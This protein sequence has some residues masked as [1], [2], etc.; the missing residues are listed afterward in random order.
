[1]KLVI[2]MRDL[3]FRN[4]TSQEK[5][6]RRL[7]LSESVNQDGMS[8]R[9]QRHIV[10]SIQEVQDTNKILEKPVLSVIKL[11]D[12]RVKVDRLFCKMKGK[13]FALHEG[14]IYLVSFVH[15]LKIELT[16]SQLF[17]EGD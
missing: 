9:S 14:K 4:L 11:H 1:M 3:L 6:R 8:A 12:S 13:I 5:K 17:E 2:K 16:D 15:T 10:Y 7:S